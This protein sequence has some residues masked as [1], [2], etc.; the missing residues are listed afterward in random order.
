VDQLQISES[1]FRVRAKKGLSA[2]VSVEAKV[3]AQTESAFR[4]SLTDLAILTFFI[5]YTAYCI[6]RVKIAARV[7]DISFFWCQW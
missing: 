6:S 3:R 5:L 7:N 1:F 2:D 4:N